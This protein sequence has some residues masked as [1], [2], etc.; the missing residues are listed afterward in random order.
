MAEA[1]ARQTTG[2][3]GLV[4]NFLSWYKRDKKKENWKSHITNMK[5]ERDLASDILQAEQIK[6]NS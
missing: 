2:D 3:L 5:V 6:R 4:I 1:P